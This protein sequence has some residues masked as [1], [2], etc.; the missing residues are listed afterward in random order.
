MMDIKLYQI[1]L[2]REDGRS[3]RTLENLALMEPDPK[4]IRSDMY[5]CVFEG[6]VECNDLEEVFMYFNTDEIDGFTGRSMSVSDVVVVRE[7]GGENAAYFCDNVG[8]TLVSFNMELAKEWGK[9]ITVVMLEPGKLARVETI[10]SSLKSLQGIVGGCIEA[11]YPFEEMVC[12]VCNDE[13]KVNGMPLNR[14]VFV[15]TDDKEDSFEMVDIIAG[16]CFICDC[17]GEEFGSLSSEQCE[18]YLSMFRYPEHFVR[19]GDEI[20]AFPYYPREHHER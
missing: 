15:K 17:S 11:Y 18:K 9:E 16:P 5:D 3:F 12:I 20:E 13:G 8:F 19:F 2:D 14:A 1:N 6:E 10:D 7:E 4:M